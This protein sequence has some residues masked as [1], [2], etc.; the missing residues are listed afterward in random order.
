MPNV[1]FLGAL[2]PRELERYYRHAEATLVPSVCFETFGIVLIESLRQ[3]TPIIARRIGPFPEMVAASAGGELFDTPAE[4]RAIMRRL[5]DDRTYRARLGDAG[6]RA[7]RELWGEAAVLTR[8]L[9]L[10]R[11]A[12]ERRQHRRVLDALAA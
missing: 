9:E 7:S 3:R 12:A 5:Q 1:S 6:Y 2:P 10:V 4:L 8:Y 11:E